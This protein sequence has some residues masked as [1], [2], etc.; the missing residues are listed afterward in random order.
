RFVEEQDGAR[1]EGS[2]EHVLDVLLRLS[3]PHVLELRIV[4]HVY[5][6]SEFARDRL[7]GHRL[8]SPRRTR[9]EEA[10]SLRLLHDL[11][12][13]PAAVHE[14]LV[15]KL[16]EGVE[17]P[18]PRLVGQD[19]VRHLVSRL[20]DLGHGPDRLVQMRLRRFAIVVRL[21]DLDARVEETDDPTDVIPGHM[22][23]RFADAAALRAFHDPLIAILFPRPNSSAER[24][25]RWGHGR[26][27]KTS[28]SYLNMVCTRRFRLAPGGE[29]ARHLHREF[30][31][32]E[33]DLFDVH[34]E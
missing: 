7:R 20:D 29:I 28:P 4:D 18:F 25:A 26:G 11:L 9:E 27:R 33:R 19:D 21:I 10:E 3:D 5:G 24:R 22:P 2:L 1:V 17:D 34:S 30:E 6:P 32:V 12:Q 16:R 13:A 15:S 23:A 8:P 31:V 14:P